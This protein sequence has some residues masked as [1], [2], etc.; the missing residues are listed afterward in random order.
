MER[1]CCRALLLAKVIPTRKA[2]NL[3]LPQAA[4]GLLTILVFAPHAQEHVQPCN[5]TLLLTCRSV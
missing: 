4:T 5:C 2:F 3:A 1:I